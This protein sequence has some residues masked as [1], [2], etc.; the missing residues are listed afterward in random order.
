MDPSMSCENNDVVGLTGL[1]PVSV[2]QI[3]RRGGREEVQ[4][5]IQVC[6]YAWRWIF[7]MLMCA[8]GCGLWQNSVNLGKL[9]WVTEPQCKMELIRR[10]LKLLR[11]SFITV[12]QVSVVFVE[13]SPGC[14]MGTKDTSLNSMERI[15]AL[16]EADGWEE[17]IFRRPHGTEPGTRLVLH[18]CEL[19]SLDFP[20][21]PLTHLVLI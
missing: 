11:D 3:L 20:A 8:R 6:S 18:K 5:D 10:S 14:M 16:S 2:L 21:N 12:F 9:F 15:P 13:H 4:V 7:S 17:M 19:P 1:T